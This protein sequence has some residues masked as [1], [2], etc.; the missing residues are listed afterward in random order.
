MSAL[1]LSII[2]GWQSTATCYSCG[3][4]FASPLIAKRRDD[5]ESFYCP[6][7]HQQHFTKTEATRLR[8]ELERVRRDLDWQKSQRQTVEKRLIAQRGLTTRAKNKLA[9]VHKG[10]CPDCNRS[11]QNLAAHMKTKHSA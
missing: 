5:G 6:N 11:F 2:C 7:G 8:E 10:V 3:V 1:S 9:R 4:E